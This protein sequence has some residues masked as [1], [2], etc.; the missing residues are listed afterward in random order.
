MK[1]AYLK[2]NK[3]EKKF[4]DNLVITR[5]QLQ[6]NYFLAFLQLPYASLDGFTS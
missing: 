3:T 2:I 4:Q 6:A 1:T 5:K